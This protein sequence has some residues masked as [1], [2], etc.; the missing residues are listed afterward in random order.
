MTFDEKSGDWTLATGKNF[1]AFNGTL[2]LDLKGGLTYGSDGNA[3]YADEHEFTAEERH[4]IAEHVRVLLQRWE[5][6][7]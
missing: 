3:E 6:K 1:H 4:E 2:G 7:R 5:E